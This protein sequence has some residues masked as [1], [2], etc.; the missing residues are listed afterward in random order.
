MDDSTP[1]KR[2]ASPALG[3]RP[4]KR[5]STSSP[6]EGELDDP[7]PPSSSDRLARPPSP[8]S[9]ARF[10]SKIKFPFKPKPAPPSPDHRSSTRFGP[11]DRQ[12]CDRAPDD[13]Q[14]RD[15]PR[16]RDHRQQDGPSSR[17]RMDSWVPGDRDRDRRPPHPPWD[18]HPYDPR[19][20]RHPSMLPHP[21]RGARDRY[22]DRNFDLRDLAPPPPPP[23][24]P[25]SPI[26]QSQS[27]SRSPSSP[28]H[29]RKHRLPARRSPAPAFSPLSRDLRSDRT[30]PES[31]DRDQRPR[32]NDV[33]WGSGAPPPG[34]GRAGR[35]GGHD[36]GESGS[37]DTS[38]SVTIISTEVEY[39][40]VSPS[41]ASCTPPPP[42]SPAPPPPPSEPM[43]EPSAEDLMQVKDDS[44]PAAHAVVSFAL[45][46]PNAPRDDHSPSPLPLPPAREEDIQRAREKRAAVG[47]ADGT[48]Q[49][50]AL[51]VTTVR[52]KRELV[53]RSRKEEMEAYGRAFE[54]C[55]KQSDYNAT[56]KV[57][58]GTFG[59]VPFVGWWGGMLTLVRR[60]RATQ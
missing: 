22:P 55:G 47:G 6:E 38:Q 46:R 24:R 20:Y 30:R 35:R 25:R 34:T 53:Q 52:K 57:G 50:G 39:R 23:H 17:R 14:R 9:A 5:P 49:A 15:R 12:Q 51:A 58:E 43:E 41:P 44:L 7:P 31:W 18:R 28:S 11:D 48:G 56:T 13:D 3:Q 2:P 32:N 19:P 10:E 59:Y 37:F 60:V 36:P 27:R 29:H 45:K 54:G 26:S 33:Y 21:P 8:A 40:P 1:T 4:A 16:F 42:R